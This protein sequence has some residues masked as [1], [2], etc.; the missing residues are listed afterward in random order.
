M[1]KNVIVV[2]LI[3]AVIFMLLAV[4]F[5]RC[6]DHSLVKPN[7]PI[8]SC[9]ADQTEG[10]APLSVHFIGTGT[11]D[12][13]IDWYHWEFGD[14]AASEEQIMNHT[15]RKAGIYTVTFSVTDKNGLTSSKDIVITVEKG[16]Y[17]PPTVFAY[18]NITKGTAPL[19]VSFIGFAHSDGIIASYNWDFSDSATSDEPRVTHTFEMGGSY[20]VSLTVTDDNGATRTA[21]VVIQVEEPSD[22]NN[23]SWF[24]TWLLEKIN[25]NGTSGIE[26]VSWLKTW[27]VEKLGEIQFLNN[28]LSDLIPRNISNASDSENYMML[29]ASAK[30]M[31]ELTETYTTELNG[32][33]NLSNDF[34]GIKKDISVC[35]YVFKLGCYYTYKGAMAMLDKDYAEASYFFAVALSYRTDTLACLV[36]LT[37]LVVCLASNLYY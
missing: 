19:T 11:S 30:H 9:S 10:T 25:G 24:K 34:C 20:N 27:L 7:E 26:A 14:G 23:S 33:S 31:Q 15:F 22:T 17:K 13:G 16:T 28:N 3:F 18:A 4:G 12:C 2:L 6:M 5:S 32:L 29:A 8:V 21:S 35:V 1:R 37:S 36:R